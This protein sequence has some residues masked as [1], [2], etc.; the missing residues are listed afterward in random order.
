MNGNNWPVANRWNV[1]ANNLH[2]GAWPGVSISNGHIT[3][4][5]LNFSGITGAVPVSIGNL[6]YLRTFSLNTGGFSANL[7][8]T[9]LNVFAPLD[10]LTS[11]TLR[12]CQLQGNIP[13]SW[14]RLKN[15]VTLNLRS[16]NLT[17]VL[18]AQISEMTKLQTLDVSY[19]KLQNADRSLA[20]IALSSADFSYQTVQIPVIEIN[21]A[22]ITVDLPAYCTY[23][24][25]DG[26]GSFNNRIFFNL[27]VNNTIVTGNFSSTE[28]GSLTFKNVDQYG[29]KLTDQI[30][31][32]QSGGSADATS[33]NY[34][35]ISFGMPLIEAEYAILKQ[36]FSATNGNNWTQKWNTA[37]NNLHETSW[38]GVGIK[39]GHVISIALPG[40]NLTGSLPTE[41]GNLSRLETLNLQ[42]N[43]ITGSIPANINNLRNLKALN[44]QGNQLSGTIPSLSV[45]T[46]L[47]KLYLSD[48]LFAGTIPSQFNQLANI[49][50]L[51]LSGNR[52]DAIATPFTYDLNRVYLNLRGQ[53]IQINEYLDYSANS[54]TLV[55]PFINAYNDAARDYNGQHLFALQ[56]NGLTVT[57]ATSDGKTL[58]F[59][60]VN[61]TL[62]PE[63]AQISLWQRT[64]AARDAI[65]RYNGIK[66]NSLVPV[67]EYEYNVLV[68]LFQQTNGSQWNEP[69]NVSSNNIHQTK[70]KGIVSNEGHIISIDLSANNLQGSIPPELGQLTELRS[71]ILR[72][73]K[74]SGTIPAELTALPK[75]TNIDLSENELTGLNAAFPAGINLKIDR[76]SIG[77]NTLELLTAAVFFDNSINRYDQAAGIFGNQSYNATIGSFNRTVSI[78]PEGLKLTSLMNQW[79]IPNNQIMVLRQ[80]G[81]AARNSTLT[82]TLT[83]KAGDANMDGAVNVLDIQAI[84]NIILN[85]Y[86]QYFNFG[87]ADL[88]GDNAINLLDV[89]LAI[90]TVQ[91]SPI[92]GQPPQE[93][94]NSVIL[95]IE[96]GILYLDN[97]YQKTGAFDIRLKGI[98]KSKIQDLAQQ[99]GYTLTITD[100]NGE[101]GI[102]GF[103]SSDCLNGKIAVAKVSENT[104]IVDA[105]IS[106][107]NATAV[108]HVIETLTGLHQPAKEGAGGSVSNYPNPFKNST[109]IKYY[110]PETVDKATLK[111]VSPAGQTVRIYGNLETSQGYHEIQ[112]VQ[113]SRSA[114]IYFYRLEVQSKGQAH[115]YNNKMII[116]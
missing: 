1:S 73:N 10:S 44:L 14:G 8:T 70:W 110:L 19:N 15:L 6:K 68:K 109:I 51:D 27:Y 75:L 26:T 91:K 36:L 40:N 88:N 22:E 64:G 78:P 52:F 115:I 58:V 32:V 7:S 50:I 90:N 105:L 72:Q 77:M 41:L 79:N 95:S 18:P 35:S 71:L 60:D 106:D 53:T 63:G 89:V 82:Y 38:Y 76:Q 17:G 57:E 39:D 83:Y 94:G 47:R 33:L 61:I 107:E 114:G 99:F 98:E 59:P 87:A 93:N 3:G 103:T 30:K 101:I 20:N 112:F 66:N 108:P 2:E 62:I 9:D 4:L 111:V 97:L 49:E 11:L 43:A 25:N 81:G 104:E 42:F 102:I 80:V 46:S 54:I 69:W 23:G 113:N 96:N 84:L 86:Q 37:L 45:I 85:Q 34:A 65:I 55:L 48:N 100:K 29:I 92:S 12:F 13:A 67:V 5:T 28:D 24:I 116:R 21:G 16:N 74:L 31:I 56:A